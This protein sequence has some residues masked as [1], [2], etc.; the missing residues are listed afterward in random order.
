MNPP[1]NG[2]NKGSLFGGQRVKKENKYK[3]P[4]N[5]KVNQSIAQVSKS[6]EA[7]DRGSKV[8]TGARKSKLL[9]EGTVDQLEV[10][11]DDIGAR[12]GL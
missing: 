7:K 11:E 10:W 3:T 12:K 2:L 6:S 4:L 1:E 5:K 9:L 8:N